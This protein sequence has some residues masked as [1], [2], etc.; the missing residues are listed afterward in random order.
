MR[1]E[2]RL[3]RA[4]ERLAVLAE[5]RVIDDRGRDAG[6]GARV[7][8]RPRRDRLETTSAISAG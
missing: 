2:H 6:F 5:R 8:G 3:Q 4:L 7:P 1:I